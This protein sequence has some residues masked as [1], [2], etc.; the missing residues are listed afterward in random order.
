MMTTLF[1]AFVLV[2]AIYDQRLSD[3]MS[4]QNALCCQLLSD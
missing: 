3:Q 4:G 2:E 1:R